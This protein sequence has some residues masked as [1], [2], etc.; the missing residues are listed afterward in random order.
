MTFVYADVVKKLGCRTCAVQNAPL[1]FGR[2]QTIASPARTNRQTLVSL[3]GEPQ[4]DD[5]RDEEDGVHLEPHRDRLPDRREM[6]NERPRAGHVRVAVDGQLRPAGEQVGDERRE[7]EH[8]HAAAGA[9]GPHRRH[10]DEEQDEQ[11]DSEVAAG[12]STSPLV[13]LPVIAWAFPRSD[14][15]RLR[16]VDEVRI[17]EK[18][19]AS[20][21]GAARAPPNRRRRRAGGTAK[22]RR[23]RAIREQCVLR[24]LDEPRPHIVEQERREHE[25]DDAMSAS[26]AKSSVESRTAARERR[27]RPVYHH[28]LTLPSKNRTASRPTTGTRQMNDRLR[29]ETDWLMTYGEKPKRK[30]AT[31]DAGRCA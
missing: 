1:G 12:I 17:V 22:R 26:V 6:L 4:R 19:C 27:E 20:T 8:P 23:D 25:A 13:N 7:R 3:L 21:S 2:K 15:R 30:P 28:T 11:R 31:S 18:N 29:C 10:R 24:E 5:E 16:R 14:P 9:P